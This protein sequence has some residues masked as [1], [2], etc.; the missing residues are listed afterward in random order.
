M[1]HAITPPPTPK[2]RHQEEALKRLL[3]IDDCAL[4]PTTLGM[5][6]K[7]NDKS[8]TEAFPQTKPPPAQ[9]TLTGF[10][11]FE[12]NYNIN[13]RHVPVILIVPFIAL[14]GALTT[15]LTRK[16]AIW[17][18]IAYFLTGLGITAGHH[19]LWCHRSYVAS[20]ALQVFLMCC[21]TAAIQGSV[22]FW[23]TDHRL[24]HRYTDTN[25]DPYSVHRGLL[26]SHIGWL[27][28]IETDKPKGHVDVSDLTSDPLLIWQDQNYDWFSPICA[29]LVPT[30]VAGLGWGDWRGG[31]VYASLVRLVFVHHATFS[32]NSLAH[33]LGD[34]P[35][36]DHSA[37]DSVVTAL[38]SLGEGY[39][40]FH[41]AYPTD[42]RNAVK[43][44]QYDP[45]KIAIR[46]YK[47]LGLATGLVTFSDNEIQKGMIQTAQKRL[48][49]W[50][51]RIAWG[52]QVDDLPVI[53]MD[54]FVSQAKERNLVLISGIVH[55]VTTWLDKHPGGRT[56]LQSAIGKDA[57]AMFYG[58]V[59]AHS[60]IARNL[61]D[62]YR[63]GIVRGG[64]QVEAW[65]S[66]GS[67]AAT[68]SNA[69]SVASSDV[70]LCE[71]SSC[72]LI[73]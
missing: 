6:A 8:F 72:E 70:D 68:R 13:W 24:H 59:Y 44:Y 66:G 37:R 27:L 65:K 26:W 21:S 49:E 54:D 31:L 34:R 71:S 28:V 45:T 16:T 62:N 56:I 2:Q 25:K 4:P 51:E 32:V 61:L 67:H 39:H 43:W 58:G 64:M 57:T 23:V 41:H 36:D 63:V 53:E 40:N 17:A 11:F 69:V 38:V 33:Y 29:L 1:L 19:R 48:D 50:N 46:V 42:Y 35:Y 30:L 5:A 20:R 60:R 3:A 14:A 10:D 47:A 18:V 7:L 15:P 12:S 52:P 55:D 9:E 22:I 73:G